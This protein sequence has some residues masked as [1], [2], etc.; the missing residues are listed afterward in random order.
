MIEFPERL[1]FLLFTSARLKIVYGGR[2]GG[3]CLAIGT[4]II[5]ADGSLRKVED[6][7]IGDQVM[8]P[9]SWPRNVLGIT[10][11]RSMM[12][13][14]HQTSG[15]DYIV[16]DAHIL[17]LKKSNAAINEIRLMKSGK[18]RSP[19]GRYPS[20]PD[21]CNINVEEAYYKSK[22][23]QDN[24]RGYRAGLLHFGFKE[25]EIDP[26]YLGA[27][28]GDGKSNDNII[29]S[30][31]QEVLD[32][33]QK[34]ANKLNMKISIYEQNKNNKSVGIKI[35]RLR[36]SENINDLRVSLKNYKLINNKHIPSEYKANSE[37]VR[38]QVL[39]GLLDTDGH[40]HNNGYEITQVNKTLIDDIKFLADGLGFRT[41]LREKKT[42]C[43]NNGVRGLAYKL[44]ING[45][46]WRIPCRI[47]RKQVKKENVNKNK[48]FLLSQIKIE[49]I[50]EGE[51]AGFSL[52]G[53]H[54][55]L[56][57]DGTV[58]HNTENGCRALILLSRTKK[59]RILCGREFQNSIDESVKATIEANIEELHLQD[60]FIITRKQIICKS[61]GSKFI[62]MGLRYNISKIKSMGR[63]DICCIEEGDKTS[64][65]TLDKLFP[66]IRGR[67]EFEEDKGGPFG[68]GPEIWIFFNPDLEDDE[69]YKRYVLNQIKY[70]P[71]FVNDKRYAIV[72]KV[73]YWDNKWFPPDLQMEMEVMR[74][75]SEDKY[76]EVWEGHT[77]QVLEGAIYA[78]EL[79]EA[80]RD[81]RR[82]IVAYDPN[83][84]VL[85]Y[86]DLGHS[87]KTAIW[88]VQ[89]AGVEFNLINY[90]EDRL[91]KIPFY[92][93][94]MNDL[95]YNYTVHNLPHDGSHETASNITPEKQ[96]RKAYPNA[97]IKVTIRPARK[98]LGI[99]AVRSLFPLLNFDEEK[100]SNG[101]QCLSRYAYKV[102]EDT[103]VFSK[104]P[105]H[106]TP[107]SHGAD[108]LQTMAL[109]IKSEA[110]ERKPK[111][112]GVKDKLRPI[113]NNNGWMGSL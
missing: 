15:I 25:I 1:A 11:G 65:N 49:P 7:K 89:R 73:N 97:L 30:M 29:Y 24:F 40:L 46:T 79:R 55:F 6:I 103:G 33:C 57:E 56:L 28:L 39:A 82:K 111:R 72:C 10:R 74:N 94:I 42:I 27:W 64:A 61:T 36:Y 69:V 12:Y 17:S 76:L 63:I 53:D 3:K 50:G 47:V 77:K 95:G 110:D 68:D 104:E 38:L 59:L 113:G 75:A 45:D 90:Y 52:D 5:M 66:T 43:S 109:S 9:D 19:N 93:K 102:D 2:G 44:F 100:T 86:W 70:A 87:D 112:E 108:A 48:D 18:P 60:D 21:V 37:Y 13:K 51:Y 81:G 31:D 67:S 107:W 22:K 88:F 41:Y 98:A 99:N 101:W 14:I 106:D 62:F 34:L 8:G 105:E 23:W 78:E 71:E 20:Y 91:K 4:K 80:I 84:P 83:K 58:T 32:E 54:L 26:W 16:N 96:L 92:I 85:T 35:A